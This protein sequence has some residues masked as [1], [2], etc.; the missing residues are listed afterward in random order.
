MM[1]IQFLNLHS[2]CTVFLW[3]CWHESTWLHLNCCAAITFCIYSLSL[4]PVPVFL[5]FLYFQTRTDVTL[6]PKSKLFPLTSSFLKNNHPPSSSP[7]LSIYPSLPSPS[8]TSILL[9]LCNL[10]FDSSPHFTAV[11]SLMNYYI[12]HENRLWGLQGDFP[13]YLPAQPN[14]VSS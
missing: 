10:T 13:V 2:E 11:L 12:V 9:C 7:P 1:I 5:H 8:A 3:F 14:L 6:K 4:C